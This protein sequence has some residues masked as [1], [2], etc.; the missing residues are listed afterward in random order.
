MEMS[1]VNFYFTVK[2]WGEI[3]GYFIMLLMVLFVVFMYCHNWYISWRHERRRRRLLEQ[4]AKE[5]ALKEKEKEA[6][7]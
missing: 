6:K 7:E 2:A 3:V 5:A 1:G 4:K